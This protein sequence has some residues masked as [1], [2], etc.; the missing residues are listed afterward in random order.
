M[1]PANLRN[2]EKF[3]KV[4]F[5][6][7]RNKNKFI[8][9]FAAE[10]FSTILR[11]A[12]KSNISS[13]INSVCLKPIKKP[14]K[15]NYALSKKLVSG[16]VEMAA[17]KEE[18]ATNEEHSE[19][20]YSRS[21]ELSD[22]AFCQFEK[23]ISS[24]VDSH[25]YLRQINDAEYL[26]HMDSNA[27]NTLIATLSTL[28]TESIYGV[29]KKLFTEWKSILEVLIDNVKDS[30]SDQIAWHVQILRFTYISLVNRCNQE[31]ITDITN[32]LIEKLGEDTKALVTQKGDDLKYEVLLLLI[33]DLFVFKE[34]K[35]CS[36]IN[37]TT[38]VAFLYKIL[39][40]LSKTKCDP[41]KV[42][43]QNLFVSLNNDYKWQK[44]IESGLNHFL[45]NL[46]Q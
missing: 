10:S 19:F 30:S 8:K 46:Y 12:K 34:G 25:E 32:L 15:F 24:K 7:L 14:Y 23:W 22:S 4:Y 17:E 45:A 13:I 39:K 16:D 36:E 1:T 40:D 28:F 31:A 21:N 44:S 20:V 35:K 37:T 3:F 43:I 42:S 26:Y 38:I 33:K 9:K 29:Q 41:S 2:L 5:N 18:L 6:I 27:R 11:K